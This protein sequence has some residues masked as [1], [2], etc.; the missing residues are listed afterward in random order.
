MR[1]LGS[2][3][4]K[5]ED[6]LSIGDSHRF[7]LVRKIVSINSFFIIVGTSRLVSNIN[8][9]NLNNASFNENENILICN[10]MSA[11]VFICI[12]TGTIK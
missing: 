6:V 12:L 5:K 3:F 9:I 8:C 1:Y 7:N 4:V 2:I 10:S 11:I